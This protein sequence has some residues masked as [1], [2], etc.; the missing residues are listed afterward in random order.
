MTQKPCGSIFENVLMRIDLEHYMYVQEIEMV[1]K[2]LD[3]K[4]LL[5]SMNLP[6]EQ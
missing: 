5:I 4:G 1:K 3:Q 2:F 6:K